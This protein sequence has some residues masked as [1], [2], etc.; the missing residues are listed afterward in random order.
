[1]GGELL[2]TVT[3]DVVV[4]DLAIFPER[5]VPDATVDRQ[6]VHLLPGEPTTFRFHGVTLAH[7]PALTSL[8]ALRHTAT[9]L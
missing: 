5:V 4:R 3:S 8:P 9:L 1:D 2:L 6:L 7:V